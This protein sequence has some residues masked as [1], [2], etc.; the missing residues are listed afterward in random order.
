MQKDVIWLNLFYFFSSLHELMQQ[1]PSHFEFNGKLLE[2]LMDEV[3]FFSVD[4]K[5]FLAFLKA[6]TKRG[7]AMVGRFSTFSCDNQKAVAEASNSLVPSVWLH[8]ANPDSLP[9][10][11]NPTY[12]PCESSLPKLRLNVSFWWPF[13]LRSSISWKKNFQKCSDVLESFLQAGKN[14]CF[15]MKS[16]PGLV[17]PNIY[18]N[19]TW[20][21]KLELVDLKMFSLHPGISCLGNLTEVNLD[22]N[23]LNYVSIIDWM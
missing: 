22:G 10:F 1:M 4:V 2:F 18:E 3:F 9:N 20:V 15:S 13:L 16:L 11:R 14:P 12:A 21:N 5:K 7:Q 6:I 8:L 17:I 19:I 23:S